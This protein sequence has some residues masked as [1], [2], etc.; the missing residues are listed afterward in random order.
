ML[1]CTGTTTT[2]TTTTSGR[3][4]SDAIASHLFPYTQ[5]SFLTG[6]TDIIR[7]GLLYSGG[8]PI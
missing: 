2:T 6:N 7:Q 5:N 8:R 4:Y 3:V 1:N